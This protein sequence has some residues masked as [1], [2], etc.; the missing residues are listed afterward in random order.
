MGQQVEIRSD[1]RDAVVR[2]SYHPV[3]QDFGALA[4]EIR[5]G[6]LAYDENVLTVRGDGLSAFLTSLADDWR[7][8]DGTRTWGRSNKA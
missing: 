3:D 5:A 1:D 6:G 8:W 4:I 2:L 7:G